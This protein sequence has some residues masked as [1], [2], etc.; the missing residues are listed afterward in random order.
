MIRFK[1]KAEYHYLHIKVNG[2]IYVRVRD[3][4]ILK[5]NYSFFVKDFDKDRKVYELNLEFRDYNGK[6]FLK[7]LSYVNFFKI[8]LGYEI[9]EIS[10]YREFFVTD[11][12]F[13]DFENIP[14][15]KMMD[16]E[17]PLHKIR[18]KEDPDFWN[19]YNVILQQTPVKD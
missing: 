12:H 6:L 1:P 10:K 2:E 8:Y 19:N 14:K 11:I 15:D 13:P 9:G 3:H 5:F 4:G 18:V 16:R 7:Y 17:T